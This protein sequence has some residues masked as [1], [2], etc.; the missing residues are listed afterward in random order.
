[1]VNKT[2]LDDR[3]KILKTLGTGGTSTVYLAENIRLGTYWA[4]KV[5]KKEPGRGINLLAEPNILKKL[6]HPALPRIFDI[7]EDN[8]NVYII[9]DY[10]DGSTLNEE[11]K[12]A[13]KFPEARVLEWA[14][15]LCEVLIYLHT[16]EPHPIIYRDM[17]PSN[18][19]LTKEG[20]VYLI[21]FGTAREFKEE[22]GNDTIYI[23]T[24]GYAPP[25]QYG[26]GQTNATTDIYSFGVTLYQLVTGKSPNEPPFELKPVRYFDMSLSEGI[27]HIISRC[28]KLDPRER[29]QSVREVLE[30]IINVQ[31]PDSNTNQTESFIHAAVH[32]SFKRLVLAVWDNTEFACE[33]AYMAAR[34]T[35]LRVLLIE[36]EPIM[37]KSAIYLGL[38]A[39]QDKGCDGGTEGY[40]FNAL[41]AAIEED[42]LDYSLIE[43]VCLKRRDV[44]NLS[45]LTEAVDFNELPGYEDINLPVLIECAYNN[46]DIT[47]LATGRQIFDK[48]TVL[49]LQKSDY[50]LAALTASM[51]RLAE[52]EKYI[53]YMQKKHNI[54]VEKTRLVAYE[55]KKEINLP[56]AV[57]R[58]FICRDNF[59][60]SIT[61]NSRR[62][63]S[64]NM[65]S[66]YA[67]WEYKHNLKE[68]AGIL[69]GFN[70]IPKRTFGSILNELGKGIF[71][72]L[73][74]RF[75]S[76]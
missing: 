13:G 3:Y 68:Y 45:V 33:L 32:T 49:S 38:K 60:G 52:F 71:L 30:D 41:K 27:E 19:M 61:Y 53:L 15:Q 37:P 22:A 26:S 21:D 40:G 55:Y 58:N 62:E 43:K 39:E 11:L 24:R 23:G 14:R 34:M 9:I 51:D 69:S 70:I 36:L 59:I 17:K 7:L 50:N 28:T 63:K 44:K 73:R 56:A 29:Y 25:E 18:I 75:S 35:G 64:R 57:L 67:K 31:K 54:T 46:Y 5:I 1:M 48:F 74:K 20:K 76:S 16:F 6:S 72:F 10:I 42:R 4:V 12:K 2:I 66:C 47:I 8:D 65:D